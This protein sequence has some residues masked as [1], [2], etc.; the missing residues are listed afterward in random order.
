M[1]IKNAGSEDMKLLAELMPR[2]PVSKYVD[3]FP[4][5]P[6]VTICETTFCGDTTTKVMIKIFKNRNNNNGYYVYK[7]QTT[8]GWKYD[9]EKEDPISEWEIKKLLKYNYILE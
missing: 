7:K 8:K 4:G 2:N 5:Y 9:C 1:N 3:A 6:Y